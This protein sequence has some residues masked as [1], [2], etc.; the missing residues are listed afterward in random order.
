MNWFFQ[1]FNQPSVAQ[2]I[3][4]CCLVIAIGMA[5]GKVK[6]FGISFG[7]TWVL[8]AGLIFS[9]C[10]VTIDQQTESFAKDF[11]LILFVYAIGLQLGPGF[12]AS[13]KKTA[14]G[15]NM[16][17]AAVIVLG[18]CITIIF[19]FAGKTGIPVLTGVLSGAVTNTPSLAAAQAAVKDLHVANTD[20]SYITLAY[21]V[22]YP[23][24][25]SG[26]IV[27]FILLKKI[28]GIDIE[29]EKE[30]LRKLHYAQSGHLAS[31]NIQLE[32][33]QLLGKP[34]RRIF[35]LL[36][37][38][39]IISRLLQN[40][41]VITPNPD[42]MLTEGDVLLVVAPKKTLEKMKMLVG[43]ETDVNLK[44]AASGSLVS[45]K[46]VVTKSSITHKRI[47]DIELLHHAPIT[48]TRIKRS[49]IEMIAHGNSFLQLGDTIT[50]VGNENSVHQF[51]EAVGNSLKRLEVP[52]LAPIFLGIVL[53]V[54][55]GSI[56]FH[57]PGMP[58]AVKIG[59]AGGP[60]IVALVLSRFG[61]HIYLNNYTTNS[62]NLILREV[63]IALF[64]A[65]VGLG[66]GH[67]LSEAFTSGVGYSW[68]GMGVCI[69][70]IPLLI[71]GIVAKKLF[72]KTYFEICG[73]LAGSYTDPPA[74]AFALK[75]AGNDIP[76]TTYATVYPLS[77]ILRILFAQLL[78]LFFS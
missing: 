71:I 9:Y 3:V 73:L 68:I 36:N 15:N 5:M 31:V 21:A 47:G 34:I 70:M 8:F 29:K 41:T 51:T 63:G 2:S 26:I 32:N 28:L 72:R 57:I 54:I 65:C 56:P 13:L 38:P 62:A 39:V 14:L 33:R 1:L 74:L 12:F 35:E 30:I 75:M 17:A 24:A 64:L 19:F 40:G 45:G 23:F 61:N 76:S 67:H 55:L 20:P 66:S 22:A 53:G 43:A 42:T 49:G 4:V 69:T 6:M 60:L 10:G 37:E 11:G 46:I 59:I 58:A 52:D 27:S 18:V 25:V 50:V 78:I 16:L 77:M 44:A 48:I 7:I